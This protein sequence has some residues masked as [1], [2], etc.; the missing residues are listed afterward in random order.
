MF[1]IY[2]KNLIY[3]SRNIGEDFKVKIK[4]FYRYGLFKM[5]TIYLE[6]EL[7]SGMTLKMLV[8]TVEDTID[9]YDKILKL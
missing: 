2:K 3:I 4:V 8:E 1:R 6:E 9:E 5:N 7:S